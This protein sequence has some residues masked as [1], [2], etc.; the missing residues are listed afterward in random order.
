M[1]I[2]VDGDADDDDDDDYCFYGMVDQ[3]KEL[4]LISSWDSCQRFSQS[5]NSDTRQAKLE[6]A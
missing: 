6:P 2:V 1:G 5:Q 4:S 3:R